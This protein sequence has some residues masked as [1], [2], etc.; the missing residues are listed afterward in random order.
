[1][2]NDSK[3]VQKAREAKDGEGKAA[4]EVQNRSIFW[5]FGF[6]KGFGGDRMENDGLENVT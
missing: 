2:G 6:R 3:A 5:S 4:V 1:M